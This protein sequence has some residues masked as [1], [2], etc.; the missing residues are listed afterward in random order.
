MRH[1]TGTGTPRHPQVQVQA[2][3]YVYIE[4]QVG[5]SHKERKITLNIKAIS[6]KTKQNET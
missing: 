2:Y 4:Y 3:R 1:I 5:P 6:Y